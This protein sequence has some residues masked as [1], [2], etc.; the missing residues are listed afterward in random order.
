M[1][2]RRGLI[3]IQRDRLLRV[4][5][6]AGSLRLTSA[7]VVMLGSVLAARWLGPDDFGAYSWAFAAVMALSVPTQFG[8]PTLI[9]REAARATA[10]GQWQDL[11]GLVRLATRTCLGASATILALTIGGLLATDLIEVDRGRA[12]L[13]GVLF[14]PFMAMAG[15]R[16]TLLRGIGHVV[17][18]Q[19]PDLVIRPTGFALAMA[20]AMWLVVPGSA[21]LAM[22]L[23]TGAAALALLAGAVIVAR[24]LPS[25]YGEAA[26]RP[27][28]PRWFAQAVPLA[29]QLATQVVAAQVAI[30]WLG[31]THTNTD[32]GLYRSALQLVA[33]VSMPLGII[34]VSVE[35]EF[36]RL[37]SL[38]DRIATQR[39]L[40]RA[41]R[42]LL[43]GTSALALPMAIFADPL[44]H[45]LFGAEYATAGD[46]LRILL[47]GQIVTAC[48]G[49]APFLLAMTGHER[50]LAWV[51]SASLAA[52]VVVCSVLVPPFGQAGA[53][54]AT[55]AV[56]IATDIALVVITRHRLGV[57]AT[58]L[59]RLPMAP[60]GGPSARAA[61][62]R[63]REVD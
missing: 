37:H 22:G 46:A 59:A 14:L 62:P 15:I 26:P 52:N 35:A 8:F 50:D 7:V 32:V 48:I 27:D 45:L 56:T 49:L 10:S 21:S 12:L 63:P 30:L 24:S 53:A 9:L 1:P 36:S 43:L 40:A 6:G 39:L 55:V 51:S 23:H 25:A 16:S 28:N 41:T 42:L 4:L 29:L 19:V 11:R 60:D 58:A 61:D 44:C 38:G 47:I 54:W 33:V 13:A 18:G 3:A 17:A 31:A 2:L 20:A 34:V 5:M 57:D